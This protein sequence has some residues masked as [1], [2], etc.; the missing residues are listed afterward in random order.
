MAAPAGAGPVVCPL[1]FPGQFHDE[2][3]GLD[4][5]LHRYYDPATGRY[6]TP[7]PLGLTPGPNCHAYV[8]NPLQWLDPLVRQ[9]DFAG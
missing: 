5:N 2:E 1:R 8:D 6:L 7:D 3:T 9:S 4:Y